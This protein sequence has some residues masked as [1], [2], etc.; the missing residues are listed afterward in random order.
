MTYYHLRGN[1]IPLSKM[2]L[3]GEQREIVYLTKVTKIP[4]RH[5]IP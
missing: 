4:G 2:A 3:A 5:D 1:Q